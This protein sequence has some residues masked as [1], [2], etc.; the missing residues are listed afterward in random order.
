[1]KTGGRSYVDVVSA[2]YLALF[3]IF[4][5]GQSQSRELRPSAHGLAY[6]SN[7]T[8][9]TA[10]ES[11]EM[12]SFFGDTAVPLPAREPLP[13]A[14][15]TSDAPWWKDVSGA[16]QRRGHVREA[17]TVVAVV[18]GAT[19]VGCLVVAALVFV[20]RHQRQRSTGTDK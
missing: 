9:D 1:M 14:K 17:L 10:E 15:N 11:S 12:Q 6:Q 5:I 3:A 18:C 4:A 2:M 13:E 7:S 20:F 8:A 16:G 19:G